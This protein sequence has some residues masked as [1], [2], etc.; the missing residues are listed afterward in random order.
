MYCYE[1]SI[2]DAWLTYIYGHQ[3]WIKHLI[4]TRKETEISFGY[5][6]HNHMMIIII[7]NY[8]HTWEISSYSFNYTHITG[9]N[10]LLQQLTYLVISNATFTILVIFISSY[11]LLLKDKRKLIQYIYK[12]T[13]TWLEANR[14]HCGS[15]EV[16]LINL[17]CLNIVSICRRKTRVGCN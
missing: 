17:I 3:S 15:M 5:T 13:Y 9:Y 16:I 10:F 1:T 6:S 8:I 11:L 7:T 14:W 4:E 2:K 12:A